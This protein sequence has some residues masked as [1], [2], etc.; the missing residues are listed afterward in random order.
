[1]KALVIGGG[2]REHAIAWSLSRSRRVDKLY[3]AP[4]NAGI[5]E[6]AECVD[7]KPN[8]IKA[9]LDFARYEWIDMTVVGPEEPLARGIVDAFRKEGK[10][11]FGPSADAARLEASKSFSKDFMRRYGIP[12][13]E[14]KVF[15]SYIHAEDYVRM[16]G[17]PI[18]I[19]ADGLAAGKGVVVAATVE[20]ASDALRR[21]MKKRE[22]GSAGD[23]VVVE[24]CLEGEEASFMAF[25][26][27]STA[28]PMAASQDHKRVFDRDEGPNTG[29]MG[30]YSPAPL[31]TEP[32]QEEVMENVI[33]PFLR[34]VRRQRMDFKGVIYAGLMVRD[35][36]PYVLEFNCRF[37][38]PETQAVLARLDTDLF[39]IMLA[40]VE[41]RLSDMQV[42]WRQEAAVCVVA[43]SG[44]YPGPY[45]KGK[46]INGLEEAKKVKGA[47]VFHAG[48]EF[49]DGNI[50]T[51][52][53]R[54]LG[55][56]GTGSDVREAKKKAY[57]AM[58]KISFE[59]MHYR[60]DIA[61]RAIIK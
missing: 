15:N 56:T 35:G 42:V 7:I 12:T 27:G 38:D 60:K 49:A 57:E 10:K 26:D 11:I 33:K 21:I 40:T 3:C 39:E 6:L 31:V 58:G 59:G 28:V 61:D 55:V 30:A 17:A 14:Y 13:G 1:M 29:G 24:E 2:G 4:G 20:E 50:V 47:F 16:K 43:A 52:G 37:G 44:G 23:K 53:G 54:V 32:L 36:K 41:D 22:F 19:K 51:S 48:T 8:D 18:V 25:T 9:L 45:Q 46:I 34:G 5:A